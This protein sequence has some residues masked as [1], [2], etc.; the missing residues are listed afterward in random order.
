[1]K[2]IN[3]R[4]KLL[5]EELEMSQ[6][7]FG[8]RI[9]LVRSG[10]SNI[11]SGK[12]NVNDRT[13][14]LICQEFYVNEEWLLEGKGEMFKTEDDLYK[15]I[16]DNLGTIDDMERKMIIEYFSMPPEHRKIFKDFMVRVTKE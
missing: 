10:V 16:V 9:A 5:R 14:K 13:I 1:M 7:A 15:V 11:E 3:R 4:V 6:E 2:D 12:R 8:E